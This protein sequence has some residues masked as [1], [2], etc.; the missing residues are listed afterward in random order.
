MNQVQTIEQ[1]ERTQESRIPMTD[2]EFENGFADGKFAEWVNGEAIVFRSPN[3]RHELIWGFLHSLLDV[4]IRAFGLGLLFSEP[5]SMRINRGGSIREP[6]LFFVANEHLSNLDE[7]R[8]NGPADLIVEIISNESV[9]RDRSDKFYEYQSGGV[10]EYWVID[11]RRGFER[12]D[13]W[14]LDDNNRFRP[15]LVDAD[16][17]YHSTVLRNFRL[18]INSLLAEQLPDPL[19]IAGKLVGTDGIRRDFGLDQ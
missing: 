10:R 13:F 7:Q 8:L 19:K 18:D 6:D 1:S 3:T 5:Y 14:V 4:Y 17:I 2:I 16:G 11:P 12:A 15:V 9:A